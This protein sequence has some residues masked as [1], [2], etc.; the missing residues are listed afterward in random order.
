MWH[1]RLGHP[2]ATTLQHV[3]NLFNIHFPEKST[4]DLCTTCCLGKAHWL[5]S[6]LSTTIYTSLFEL[7]FCHLWRHVPFAK[8][9][10][11]YC[12]QTVQ[13]DGRAVI[14]G[15]GAG[16]WEF[17]HFNKFLTENGIT[18][19]L[20]CPLTH[21]QN[22]VVERKYRLIVELGLTLLAQTSLPYKF[23]DH[24]FTT[25]IYLI[26]RLPTNSL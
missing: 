26:N 2:N 4:F 16:G 1:Q 13:N 19:T 11:F 25:A 15:G 8:S 9:E 23:P 21:H 24:A 10:A 17:K 22:G 3:L 12:F 20:I 7:I 5:H 18:R 6:Q 14:G